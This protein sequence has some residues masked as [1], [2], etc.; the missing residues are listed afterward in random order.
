MVNDIIVKSGIIRSQAT[1]ETTTQGITKALYGKLVDMSG[2]L[3]ATA[4]GG[5]TSPVPDRKAA[6][7]KVTPVE[8]TLY[9]SAVADKVEEDGQLVH[10]FDWK[11]HNDLFPVSQIHSAV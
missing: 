3:L 7:S 9:T 2:K 10:L 6:S 1:L 5:A 8:T 4:D 11:P